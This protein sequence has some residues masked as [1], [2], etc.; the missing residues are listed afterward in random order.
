[1]KT[2]LNKLLSCSNKLIALSGYRFMSASDQGAIFTPYLKDYSIQG[3]RFTLWI[4]DPISKKWYDGPEQD[5]DSVGEIRGLASLAGSSDNVLEIGSHIGFHTIF[6][7][8][9]VAPQGRVCGIEAS[10]KYAPVAQAQ[11]GLNKL[12]ERINILNP[13]AADQAGT[14][15]FQ[16]E[17]VERARTAD[18][19]QVQG[20]RGDDLLESHGPFD[21]LKV[22]VEGYEEVVLR[23]C[24]AIL[25]Q[26]PRLA[27]EIHLDLLPRYGSSV[28]ALFDLIGIGNYHG[29]MMIR[30]DW[31]A[32]H[33]F[34]AEALPST[35]VANLFL[36]PIG[37]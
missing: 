5:W 14:L 36:V 33:D 18:D 20:I 37:E 9:C 26:K 19:I 4:P 32:L 24:R 3:K 27:L 28:S 11:V 2:K 6:L 1:M 31:H 10:P 8:H 12:C 22:D 29:T 25:K 23:G 16:R 17:H 15:H 35:G 30:P 7:A 13:A 34:R 21:V